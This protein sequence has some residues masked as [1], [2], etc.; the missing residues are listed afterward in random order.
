MEKKKMKIWKKILIIVLIL[1][2]ILAIFIT[3]KFII[4]NNLVKEAKEYADKTNYIAVVQSLQSGNVSMLKSYNKDGNHLTIM[5]TYGKDAQNERGLTVYKKDNEKI[6]IIQSGEEKI[7]ILDG[8]ILGEVNVVNIFST[9]DN[10]IQQLQFAAMSR[11]TTDNYNNI[12]CYLVELEHWKMWVEK[13]TGLVIREINGGI[14]AERFYQFDVVKDEDIT[15]PD[16]SDC[17]I[18]E[19]N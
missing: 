14:V 7:A 17:K 3:R 13:D 5:R 16:I 19:N 1:S 8:T 9:V 4:I 6:G 11:I 18:Q 12:E 2:T 15:K 10:T